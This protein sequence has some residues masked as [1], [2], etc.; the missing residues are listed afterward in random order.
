MMTD[1][2][3][4]TPREFAER[5]LVGTLLQQPGRITT[6]AQW[7]DPEDFRTSV[8]GTVFAHLRDMINESQNPAAVT[9]QALLDRLLSSGDIGDRTSIGPYLL[10]LVATAPSMT[11][12]Q[13][14][15]YAQMV[16][17]ASIRRDVER[18]GMRVAQVTDIQ[19]ELADLLA[20]V[21]TALNQVDAIG[22]RWETA[23]A[24]H[25]R[26][27][28][29]SEGGGPTTVARADRWVDPDSIVSGLDAFAS[30]PDERDLATAE[31]TVIA[32]VLIRPEALAG[33][34][35]RLYPEDFAD[36][37]IGNAFRAAIE[38]YT[39]G[40]RVDPV[41]VAWEQQRHG[42][43]HGPGMSPAWMVEVINHGPVGNLDYATDVVMRGALARLTAEAAR[44]TQRVAQH[45]GLQPA[46]V[47]HTTRLA[48]QAV[49]TT[50]ARMSG[51]TSTTTRL[52]GLDSPDSVDAGRTS[53]QVIQLRQRSASLRTALSTESDEEKSRG[54][55]TE[56]RL[57]ASHDIAIEHS[58]DSDAPPG[59]EL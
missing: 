23:T 8:N 20:A 35:D 38:I 28:V 19:P 49:Q 9:A 11:S 24:L 43:Q 39:A 48:F 26:S 4:I 45:P 47:V 37:R 13:P 12:A 29:L 51:A 32:S 52:A 34:L 31:E 50:V 55:G 21:Q 58:L 15:T 3:S 27:R 7:L 57:N 41:T 56:T 2:D 33:L 16:L 54:S 25:N 22:Q 6:I 46:D 59:V 36:R 53:A 17:E 30:P 14:E 40:R 5:A 18:W 42:A 1:Q 10:N 44:T